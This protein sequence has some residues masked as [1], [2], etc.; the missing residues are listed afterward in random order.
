LRRPAQLF[1]FKIWKGEESSLREVA[2]LFWQGKTVS[3][4]AIGA[5]VCQSNT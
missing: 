1:P 4:Q 5:Q 3:P 2:Q